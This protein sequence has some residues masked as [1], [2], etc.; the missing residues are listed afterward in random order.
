[1]KNAIIKAKLSKYLNETKTKV[2]LEVLSGKPGSLE[3]GTWIDATIEDIEKITEDSAFDREK[4]GWGK[5]LDK[6]AAEGLITE[7]ERS[8]GKS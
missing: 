7:K 5:Y 4:S 1:M 3:G 2:I 6:W 8:T